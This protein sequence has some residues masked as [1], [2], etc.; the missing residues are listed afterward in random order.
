MIE[1]ISDLGTGLDIGT[2]KPLY[3]SFKRE[4][5]LGTVSTYNWNTNISLGG[6]SDTIYKQPQPSSIS[7]FAPING[8]QKIIK[9]KEIILGALIDT[10]GSIETTVVEPNL[11][12]NDKLFKNDTV[13]LFCLDAK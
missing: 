3:I 11:K 10:S 13:Y 1:T 5:Q 6:K 4:L 9:G 8:K 2:E 12:D 7:T